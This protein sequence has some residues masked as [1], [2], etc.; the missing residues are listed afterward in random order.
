MD[1]NE[2]GQQGENFVNSVA[3]DSFVKYWCYPNPL[4]IIGD[5]K[6]ICDLLIIFDTTCIIVSVK[7]YS[8][9]GDY[10]NYFKKTTSK[11]IRQ[12]SG[13]ERKLFRDEP[14]LLKHPDRDPEEFPKNSITKIYRVV[15]NLNPATKFYQTSFFEDGKH[16][17]VMD[18]QAWR[19]ALKELNTIPDFLNYLKS[20]CDLFNNYPA[21]ILP[22]DEHDFGPNDGNYLWQEMEKMTKDRKVT[23]VL[24]S[25]LDLIALYIKYSFKFPENLNHKKANILTMKID[26]EWTKYVKSKANSFKEALE[27]ES[28]FIDRLVKEIL[29]RQNNG[30][31]LAKMFFKL[32][33]IE[34]SVFAKHYL[35]Y[36]KE[37][38]ESHESIEFNRT[39]CILPK[40]NMVFIYFADNFP[41]D[42]LEDYMHLSLIHHNYLHDF[43]IKEVGVLGVSKSFDRF[44]FG[45]SEG[46]QRMDNVEYDEYEMVFKKL[47]WKI[48]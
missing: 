8:F 20:R 23:F 27:K 38:A 42:R 29:I 46:M 34:R 12:V 47:G 26:G 14:I 32:D 10:L 40:L 2:K 6:E 7:N 37:I 21:Y 17:I 43:K 25:E 33:R 1:A 28:Y 16:Y 22:R 48:K 4:D 18:A 11:A 45:H 41:N 30:H 9:K 13:A 35:K 39:H 31:R 5:N 24:G 19:D 15:V 44:A 3:F 36:H